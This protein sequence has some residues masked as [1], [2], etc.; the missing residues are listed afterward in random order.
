MRRPSWKRLKS[1][2]GQSMVEYTLAISVV[3]V[4][5]VAAGYL[6]FIPSLDEGIKS[7]AGQYTTYY[8][9]PG[10]PKTN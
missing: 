7:F 3:V 6:G 4:A 10:G 9:D 2:R 1:E 8:A 5:V